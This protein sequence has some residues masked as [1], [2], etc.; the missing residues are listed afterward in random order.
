RQWVKGRVELAREYFKAGT[1]YFKRVQNPRCRLAC[2]AYIAR[3]DWLLDTLEREDYCLRHQYEERKHLSTGLRMA[4]QTISSTIN[5]RRS[6][7]LYEP[8]LSKRTG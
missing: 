7:E 4:W 8:A 3:F 6:G 5:L 1:G 2:F